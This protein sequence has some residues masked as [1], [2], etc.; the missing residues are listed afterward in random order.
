[1][2]HGKTLLFVD[3]DPGILASLRRL[4]RKEGW[5]ILLAGSAREGLD[6]LQ[7]QPVDLVVSDMRMPEVD[8]AAFLRQVRQQ[9]P[10]V[11]RIIL[12]GYAERQAV[13]RAFDQA[14]IHQMISKPWNDDELKEILRNA[15]AQTQDQESVVRGLHA[16]IN[17]IDALPVLPHI[18][19]Q[20]HQALSEKSNASAEKIAAVIVQDPAIAAKLLQ[21]ANSAFFGQRRQVDTVSRA[22]VVLGLEMVENLV[23][24]TGVFRSFAIEKFDDFTHDSIWKHSIGCGLVA[25]SIARQKAWEQKRQEMAMLAGTLHDLGKL[26]LAQAMPAAYAKVI[27]RAREEKLSV[28]QAEHSLLGAT[29]AA[30][31]AY[32]ADWWNLPAGIVEAIRHHCDP[33]AGQADPPLVC[34]VHLADLLMHRLGIVASQS[35]RS[36]DVAPFVLKSLNMNAG[37]LENLEVALREKKPQFEQF[38]L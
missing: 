14:D 23:L 20:V 31:G 12:T 8:G 27:R 22:L 15:L 32:L 24:A 11:I 3:D 28:A 10:Q 26:V 4:L 13:V 29:H 19:A 35:G 5:N 34:L 6:L 1:M 18:Y 9:Y 36:T 21:I 30:V 2:N 37:E 7:K 17:Q 16:I 38:S 25:H 33:A